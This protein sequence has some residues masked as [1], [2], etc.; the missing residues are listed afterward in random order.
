MTLDIAF[1][2]KA[3]QTMNFNQKLR[4]LVKFFIAAAWAVTLPVSFASS[5][6]DSLC[7]TKQP[8]S[9]IDIFCLSPYMIVVAVYLMTNVIGM[10]LFFV[11]MVSSY[12]ETS[13]LW[14]C[15]ILSWWAQVSFLILFLN[16]YL[17]FKYYIVLSQINFCITYKNWNWNSWWIKI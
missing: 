8:E 10:A 13:N 2:W 4:F 14:V 5:H 11:P 16:M 7:H 12:V 6:G 1:T 9:N 3:R 15:N 17:I